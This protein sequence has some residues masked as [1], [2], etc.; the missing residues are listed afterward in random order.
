MNKELKPCPFCGGKA[1]IISEETYSGHNLFWVECIECD[2]RTSDYED[3]E[4]EAIES[5]N[6]R[7][8]DE[9]QTFV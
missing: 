7:V 9:R 8:A 1:E 5:W 4:K 2:C 3:N 6:R